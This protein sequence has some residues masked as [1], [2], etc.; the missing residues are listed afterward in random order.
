MSTKFAELELTGWGGLDPRVARVYRP[1]RRRELRECLS[2]DS[3]SGM[4][5][6]GLGRSY[7]DAATLAG[8]TVV[9]G[10][11]LNRLLAFDEQTGLLTCEAGV[12]FADILATFVP[13]GFF[14]PVTPGT[15]F[16]TLGGAIA[17]DIHGKNHHR[18]GSLGNFVESLDLWTGTNELL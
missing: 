2:Q 4:I 11:R 10:E 12:S 7:G 8:G 9:L 18:H 16:V 17:A 15:K 5:P 6:R 3:P 14:L 13:R 1:A